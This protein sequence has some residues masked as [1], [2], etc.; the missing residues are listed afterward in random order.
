MLVSED[1]LEK[2]D[3]SLDAFSVVCPQFTKIGIMTYVYCA[4]IFD[5]AFLLLL[6]A[7]MFY[8]YMLLTS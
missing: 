7:I 5:A 1:L 8:H 4:Y 6:Y 3:L 2:R